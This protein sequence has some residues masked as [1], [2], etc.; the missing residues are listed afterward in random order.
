MMNAE[1]G[2]S[3]AAPW[4][5]SMGQRAESRAK[6]HVR[7]RDQSRIWGDC[8]HAYQRYSNKGSI[9]ICTKGSTVTTENN[10][11]GFFLF[12]LVALT[13]PVICI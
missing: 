7:E 6:A 1:K 12:F 10:P 2:D 9:S 8:S 11:Q 5:G 13:P 4:L 3:R